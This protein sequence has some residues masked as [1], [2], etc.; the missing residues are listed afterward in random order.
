MRDT[1]IFDMLGPTPVVVSPPAQPELPSEPATLFDV[2]RVCSP[3]L[4]LLTWLQKVEAKKG[5]PD[6]VTT[7]LHL[8]ERINAGEPIPELDKFDRVY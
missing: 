1:A 2:Y 3:P 5:L 6:R 8:W 4:E 7:W